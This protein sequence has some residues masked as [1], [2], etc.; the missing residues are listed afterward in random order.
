VHGNS[1]HKLK[2]HFSLW[3]LIKYYFVKGK[4]VLADALLREHATSGLI[5]SL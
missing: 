1:V 5:D 3:K 2:V 4:P